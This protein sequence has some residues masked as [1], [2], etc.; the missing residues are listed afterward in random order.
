MVSHHC[1]A[2][3]WAT[4]SELWPHCRKTCYSVTSWTTRSVCSQMDKGWCTPPQCTLTQAH[5][6]GPAT[7]WVHHIFI[8]LFPRSLTKEHTV[9]RMFTLVSTT[10][11]GKMYTDIPFF[12]L[13]PFLFM[14]YSQLFWTLVLA[15]YFLPSELGLN[16]KNVWEPLL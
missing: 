10:D 13:L 14:V 3:L 8:L 15:I 6:N 1:K 12:S 4:W 2:F 16:L 7:N 5:H 11:T 9:S